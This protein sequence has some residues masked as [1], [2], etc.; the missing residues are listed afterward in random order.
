MALTP[1][2][3]LVRKLRIGANIP[4]HTMTIAAGKHSSYLSMVEHGAKEVSKD[5]IEV[6]IKML[7][8]Q[9]RIEIVQAASLSNLEYIGKL[10]IDPDTL[11]ENKLQLAI[12]FAEII[13]TLSDNDTVYLT[14][15]LNNLLSPEHRYLHT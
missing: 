3:K 6:A 2:G 14:A 7:G 1:Y 4:L 12:A 15:V 11:S 8:E 5:L 10:S 13:P 9:H